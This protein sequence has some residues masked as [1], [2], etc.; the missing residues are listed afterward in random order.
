MGVNVLKDRYEEYD[1]LIFAFSSL[2]FGSIDLAQQ[3]D[4]K[5]AV[6]EALCYGREKSIMISYGSPYIH[7]QYFRLAPAAINGWS[8]SEASQTAAVKALFGELPFA[9][10]RP[11]AKTTAAEAKL[12]DLV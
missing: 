6:W 8:V 5:G 11:V 9:G 4:S 10:R 2:G 12:R 7:E 3:P 1:L